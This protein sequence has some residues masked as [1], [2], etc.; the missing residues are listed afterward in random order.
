MNL[1]RV[2]AVSL[3]TITKWGRWDAA[4][5]FAAEQ[6]KD[7]MARLTAQHT[8]AELEEKVRSV[9]FSREVWGRVVGRGMCVPTRLPGLKDYSTG[10]LALALAI[11]AADETLRQELVEKQK[12]LD[13][14]KAALDNLEQ[15][16]KGDQ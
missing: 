7:A 15:F 8:R 2:G 12:D 9:P 1:P 13:A 4:F 3:S 6:H 11:T 16:L 10:E 14:R 5:V